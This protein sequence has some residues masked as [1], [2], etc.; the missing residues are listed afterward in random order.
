MWTTRSL[1][2]RPSVRSFVCSFVLRCRRATNDERRTPDGVTTFLF[3]GKVD[4][5][6]A[7]LQNTKVWH[8]VSTK[9]YSQRL[10]FFAGRTVRD[11]T[12]VK[13]NNEGVGNEFS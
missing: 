8:T 13:G 2:V 5:S 11:Q 7:K 6:A 1:F 4:L 3:C 12:D 10:D 9:H